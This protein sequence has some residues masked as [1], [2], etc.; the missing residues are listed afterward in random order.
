MAGRPKTRLAR[1]NGI[2][3][4]AKTRKG[5]PCQ[6]KW[7][8]NGGRCRMHGGNAGVKTEEG[9]A[10]IAAAVKLRWQAYREKIIA[11]IKAGL[12]AKKAQDGFIRPPKPPK[13]ETRRL[14]NQPQSFGSFARTDVTEKSHSEA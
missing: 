9:K 5:T 1:L 14:L 12:T 11:D 2:A 4:G 6:A 3:C 7:L 13:P 8:M 10:R